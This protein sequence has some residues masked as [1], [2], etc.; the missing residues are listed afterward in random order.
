MT[1]ETVGDLIDHLAS[2]GRDRTLMV[3]VDGNTFPLTTDDIGLWDPMSATKDATHP[4]AFFA[5]NF[6][7]K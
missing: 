6:L 1:L 2:L 3:D 7:D 5:G 4:V